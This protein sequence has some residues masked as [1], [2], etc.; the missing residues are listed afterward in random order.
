MRRLKYNGYTIV[1]Q[2]VPN[3]ISLAINISDCP[4]R[5]KGCHSMYLWNY[6]GNYLTDEIDD[7]LEKYGNL[8][9]CVCFMGGD[10]N[11]DELLCCLSKVK[12]RKLKTCLY[13]GNDDI[14]SISKEIIKNLDYVK[15]G[16]YIEDLGGLDCETTNQKMFDLN[17]NKEIFFYK[18][19][20]EGKLI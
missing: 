5:C 11:Q 2:E 17:N 8:I 20:K 6:I 12:E 15:I 14:K 3:E 19:Q 18:R 1:M 9:S 13:T 7:L 10:Q 16:R 4:Y